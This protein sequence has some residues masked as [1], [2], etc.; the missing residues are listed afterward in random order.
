M[1][2][3]EEIISKLQ[4]FFFSYHLRIFYRIKSSYITCD[5]VILFKSVVKYVVSPVKLFKLICVC[6]KLILHHLF[7][8]ETKVM[9]LSVLFLMT[10]T[11]SVERWIR[12][13]YITL[14]KCYPVY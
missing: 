12:L 3:S 10:S 1:W 13:Y 7:M 4:C 6:V 11:K 8:E 2:L 9:K 5:L 14:N